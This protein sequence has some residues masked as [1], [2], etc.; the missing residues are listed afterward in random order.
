[1]TVL[2]G[3]G[4]KKQGNLFQACLDETYLQALRPST[5][6]GET[7]FR[8]IPQ[9]RDGELMPMVTRTTPVGPDFSNIYVTNVTV[10]VGLS[11]KHSG[12]A[13]P[14]DIEVN[15]EYD[16]VF[17][18][19]YIRLKG[20]LN[21]NRLTPAE[22][23]IVAPLFEGKLQ[24]PLKQSPEMALVQCVVLKYNDTDLKKPRPKQV[25]FLTTAAVRSLNKCLT[26]AHAAGIDVFA[27]ESGRLIKL[28]PYQPEGLSLTLFRAVLCDPY[29]L[30]EETCKKLWV[31]WDV[32]LK[33]QTFDQQIAAACKC[34]GRD[35]VKIAFPDD[36]ERIMSA[37]G[38]AAAPTY[39]A[40]AA[41]AAAAPAAKESRTYITPPVDLDTEVPADSLDEDEDTTEEHVTPEAVA[42]TASPEE[43]EEHYKRLLEGA[44]LLDESEL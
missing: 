8:P 40:P 27:P 17:P 10:N 16:M 34:F 2:G 23:E 31:D 18:G 33:R 20:K 42:D 44:P 19:L 35:I 24:A 1:M 28:E 21:K 43:L 3:V 15:Q 22:R 7:I 38:S 6:K 25:L 9:V 39:A 30:K 14:S 41:T 5:A 4:E 11:A 36:V 12:I 32:A 26:E 29:P 13:V 37:G